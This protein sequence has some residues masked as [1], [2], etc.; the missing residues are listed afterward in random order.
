MPGPGHS[1]LQQTFPRGVKMPPLALGSR[2]HP[3]S[4]S[5]GSQPPPPGREVGGE[6]SLLAPPPF[7]L[8][9]LSLTPSLLL[10]LSFPPSLSLPLPPSF[11]PP[12][13]PPSKL[14]GET[15]SPPCSSGGA[16]QGH[17]LHH[18]L[19]SDSLPLSGSGSALTR[20]ALKCPLPSTLGSEVESPL[21]RV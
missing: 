20:K 19:A 4:C 6:L 15:P 8:S 18:P 9:L 12:T 2:P 1:S 7:C 17:C 16:T 3:S 5:P 10:S 13:A 14:S 11:S 21:S